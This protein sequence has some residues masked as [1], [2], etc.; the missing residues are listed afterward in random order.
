MLIQPYVCQQPPGI[1]Y[2]QYLSSSRLPVMQWKSALLS[3]HTEMSQHPQDGMLVVFK[4]PLPPSCTLKGW[5]YSVVSRLSS[6]ST[7]RSFSA[8]SWMYKGG[9][10][11][12][13]LRGNVAAAEVL[14]VQ[15][16]KDGIEWST[17]QELTLSINWT[18][19]AFARSHDQLI[20]VNLI[21]DNASGH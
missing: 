4:C 9:E 16:R 21:C 10:G 8:T 19:C 12:G 11:H 2:L 3:T 7:Y 15:K 17:W 5:W 14:P 20:Q 18:A 1:T 6:V 13:L